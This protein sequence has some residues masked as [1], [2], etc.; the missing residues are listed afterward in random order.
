MGW[1]QHPMASASWII[2]RGA[3]AVHGRVATVAFGEHV[4]SVVTPG[5][6]PLEVPV[7]AARDGEE[8]FTLAIQAL[9]GE[10]GLSSGRGARLLVIVSDGVLVIPGEEAAGQRAITRLAR[11]GAGILWLDPDGEARVMP[12]AMRIPLPSPADAAALIARA[13]ETALAAV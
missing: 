9:D 4:T 1:A 10:L 8:S 3:V 7:L 12:G 2:A 11:S 13:A 6:V 5:V